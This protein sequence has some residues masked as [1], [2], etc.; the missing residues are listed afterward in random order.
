MKEFG[1][2]GARRLD[3]SDLGAQPSDPLTRAAQLRQE[4]GFAT[5]DP[6]EKTRRAYEL[7]TASVPQEGVAQVPAEPTPPGTEQEMMPRTKRFLNRAGGN[8]AATP[9][10]AWELMKGAATAYARPTEVPGMLERARKGFVESARDLGT[11]VGKTPE[12]AGVSGPVGAAGALAPEMLADLT[13]G[14]LM[15]WGARVGGK[16]LAARDN[17]PLP[18]RRFPGD[19]KLAVEAREGFWPGLA[20][21]VSG[22]PSTKTIMADALRPRIAAVNAEAD[23]LLGLAGPEVAP[24]ADDVARAA[25]ARV[26]L[27]AEKRDAYRA[28][29]LTRRVGPFSWGGAGKMVENA[30]RG[31]AKNAKTRKRAIWNPTDEGATARGVQ[32]GLERVQGVTQPVAEVSGEAFK[33]LAAPLGD[34]TARLVARTARPNRATPAIGVGDVSASMSPETIAFLNQLSEAPLTAGEIAGLPPGARPGAT[35]SWAAARQ[36]RTEI[37]DL[38]NRARRARGGELGNINTKVLG[39]VYGALS[40]EMKAALAE[41]PDLLARFE[42]G[43]A[44]QR[45]FRRKYGSKGTMTNELMKPETAMQ[46]SQVAGRVAKG[47]PESAKNLMGV[48][49]GVDPGREAMQ[50]GVVDYLLQKTKSAGAGVE[51]RFNFR[52]AIAKMDQLPAYKQVLGAKYDAF[53]RDLE[54]LAKS[55]EKGVTGQIGKQKFTVSPTGKATFEPTKRAALETLLKGATVK[56]PKVGRVIYGNRLLRAFDLRGEQALRNAGWTEP[57]IARIKEFSEA[58]NEHS[59]TTSK[60]GAIGGKVLGVADLG[61]VAAMMM[62]VGRMLTG[63]VPSGA[64]LFGSAL[65]WP[66]SKRALAAIYFQPEGPHLLARAMQTGKWGTQ[67]GKVVGAASQAGTV[68]NVTRIKFDENGDP[69]K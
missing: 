41:H 43:D 26:A 1:D 21:N 57:E 50:S 19:Y 39:Q 20:E 58:I 66:A 55:Q 62:G 6:R 17:P 23:N 28:R 46:P 38:L 13:T 35:M 5:M 9:G 40:D 30:V 45:S 14:W 36:A 53:K 64:A 16:A 67:A 3:F 18:A 34:E 10:A 8:L 60:A 42:A 22:S 29:E 52:A 49:K 2:L 15:P 68:G 44:A 27:G 51:P 37:G 56:E 31:S 61:A 32:V 69:V 24:V 48:L 59:Q 12:S 65:T 4:P 47:T 11:E 25:A 33:K 7:V 63:H 54:Y